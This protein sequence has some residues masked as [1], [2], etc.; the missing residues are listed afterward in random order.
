MAEHLL[1]RPRDVAIQA[2][3]GFGRTA[4]NAAAKP[5]VLPDSWRRETFT[6]PR[7]D[8]RSKAREMFDRFPRAAYMTEVESWQ[9]LEGDRIQFTMRRLPTAD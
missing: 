1:R 6:L 5:S 2:R 8:A 4:V 7:E 9:V 3:R